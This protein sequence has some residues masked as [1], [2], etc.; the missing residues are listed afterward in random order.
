MK[1]YQTNKFNGLKKI[2]MLLKERIYFKD[3]SKLKKDSKI[4]VIHAN[5][6]SLKK[7]MNNYH[8][9]LIRYKKI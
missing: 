7:D 9:Y 8:E 5:D 4:L 3:I 1:T 6:L 2:I